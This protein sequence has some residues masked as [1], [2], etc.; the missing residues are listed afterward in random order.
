MRLI[1]IKKIKF[2]IL[3]FIVTRMKAGG[4]SGKN[5]NSFLIINNKI[6]KSLRYHNIK[7]NLLK[8]L[9]RVPQKYFNIYF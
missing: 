1:V 5:F 7:A 3:N 2:K 9:L 4:L 6:L 8:I